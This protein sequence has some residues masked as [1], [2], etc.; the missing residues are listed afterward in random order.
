M[1]RAG[2]PPELAEREVAVHQLTLREW[3]PPEL[4]LRAVVSTGTYVRALARDIGRALGCG[5]HL[6]AL[7]R[8]RIGPFEVEQ[9]LAADALEPGTPLPAAAALDPARALAW[10]PARELGR[11]EASR[12]AAGG[13]VPRGTILDPELPEGPREGTPVRLLWEGRLL[14]VA[15]AA[16]GKLIPR[17]VLA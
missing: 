17:K 15:E 4:T 10:L 7:R 2:D 13:A 11:E 16:S 9:A 6:G 5:A 3:T 8:T 1:S 14:G 12:A